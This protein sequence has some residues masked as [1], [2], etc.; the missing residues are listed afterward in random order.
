MADRRVPIAQRRQIEAHFAFHWDSKAIYD[1]TE[2]LWH[3]PSSL[4]EP[5]LDSLYV[6]LISNSA[7]FSPLKHYSGPGR[8]GG[9]GSSRG[10]GVLT[11]IAMELRCDF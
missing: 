1:E 4:R 2:I 11:K 9:A 8:A 5:I 6:D 10:H 7:L 3:L